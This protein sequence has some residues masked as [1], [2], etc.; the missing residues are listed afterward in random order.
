MRSRQPSQTARGAPAFRAVHQMLEHGVIFK[1]PFASRILDEQTAIA[2]KGIAADEALRPWRLFIVFDRLAVDP[3]SELFV[4]PN[5]MI[6]S[7]PDPVSERGPSCRLPPNE[8]PSLILRLAYFG[9]YLVGWG[10]RPYKS[11]HRRGS[12]ALKPGSFYRSS[13]S[14]HLRSSLTAS[15]GRRCPSKLLSLGIYGRK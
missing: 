4:R 6:Q 3:Y 10:A 9:R 8:W 5:G 14:G 1:D 15:Q 7:G 11:K 2:L 12:A 13:R